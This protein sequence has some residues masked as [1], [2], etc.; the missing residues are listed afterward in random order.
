MFLEVADHADSAAI[1]LRERDRLLVRATTGSNAPLLAS[2]VVVGEGFAGTIAATGQPLFVSLASPAPPAA[3]MLAPGSPGTRGTGI[4]CLFGVP[5]MSPGEVIG[6]LQIGSSRDDLSEVERRLLLPTAERA[7]WAIAQRDLARS[8]NERAELLERERAS[9]AEAEFANRAKNDFL[10]TVSHELRT[11]LNAML[12]WTAI[13]RRQAPPQMLRALTLIERNAR[14]QT[15]IIEDVLSFSHIL[16]GK[17]RLEIA[18]TDIGAA[19]DDA[20][21]AVRP[22]ADAKGIHLSVSTVDVGNVAADASRI[23]QVVW[24]LLS[25]AIKFTPRG[26]G[27]ELST[28]SHGP[29]FVIRVADTG[30]GID[31]SFLPHIFDPFRQADG[32]STR[33]HGGLGLGL[34][35][36]KQLVRAHGGFVAAASPGVN[37]G[38][39][40]T[41]ELPVRPAASARTQPALSTRPQRV[42]D[43][44][45]DRLTLLLVV[46]DDDARVLLEESLS[47]RGALVACASSARDALEQVPALRPMVL[48]SDVG[49]A[50]L[51]ALAFIK[52]VRLLPPERG[53]L[54]PAI[55]LTAYTRTS[56]LQR[57]RAAGF[58]MHVAKPVDLEFLASAIANLAGFPPRA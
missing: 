30:E 15:R 38:S 21:E 4:R 5:L 13:A 53:G 36:V 41:I 12:G 17:L 39:T 35:I 27:I 9:R 11:P 29:N 32:S 23:R 48:V 43:V 8:R 47:A 18:P 57:A 49:M 26:G 52:D 6:V 33:R 7:A 24:N 28:A 37:Q 25:N 56:D 16:S 46:D 55:A 19:I 10:A 54:T 51:N 34:A 22:G 31:P 1:L 58:Q 44:N 14:A 2:E 42:A 45:L 50:D 20:L 40:F 3:L